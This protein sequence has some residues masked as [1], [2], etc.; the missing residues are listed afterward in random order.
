MANIDIRRFVDIDIRHHIST[1]VKSTR[2]T[3]ILFTTEG[4]QT[5]E[6]SEEYSSF[7]EFKNGVFYKGGAKET[8]NTYKYAAMYFANSGV[9]L[10]VIAINTFSDAESFVSSVKLILAKLS[11]EY[12]V[13]A[14]AGDSTSFMTSLATNLTSDA[15]YD[16]VAQKIILARS[17]GQVSASSINNFAVKVSSVVGAEMT[18]AAYLSKIDVYGTNTVQDYMYTVEQSYDSNIDLASDITDEVYSNIIDANNNVDIYLSNAVRNCG[19]NLTN[20]LD[21]VNQFV[22]IILHQVLTERVLA[23]L[24][25]KVKGQIGLAAIHTAM[26][27]EMT[28]FI[29]NG[30]LSTDEIWTDETKS[31][32]YN[33]LTYDIIEKNT[34]L[35]AGY[36]IVILPIMSLSETDKIK[37][38]TPP[39]YIVLADSE[40]IRCATI[41]GEAI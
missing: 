9:K 7:S 34:A 5:A 6:T 40:G 17:A 25:S 37:H 22:L 24:A 13:I 41:N 3:A 28:N 21:L 39:I 32:S 11:N 30:Y 27:N 18:I 14:Y 29:R 15:K 35:T 33:G 2:Q 26:A 38:S 4:N 10:K 31:V 36:K 20:G 8:T 19:G 16:G 12:I 23:I 1:N